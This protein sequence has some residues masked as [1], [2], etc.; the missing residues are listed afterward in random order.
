MWAVGIC[1][2]YVATADLTDDVDDLLRGYHPGDQLL[3]VAEGSTSF[4]RLL[5]AVTTKAVD[6][7]AKKELEAKK[8]ASVKS[9]GD[10]KQLANKAPKM[11]KL[12]PEIVAASGKEDG[13]KKEVNQKAQEERA[14]KEKEQKRIEKLKEQADKAKAK[15]KADKEQSVKLKEQAQKK[16]DEQEKKVI[17]AKEQ[18]K[19]EDE[20]KLAAKMAKLK[21]ERE[22]QIA[23][24][25]KE[26]KDI[27][28]AKAKEVAKKNERP[29][30][31]AGAIKMQQEADAE[32]KNIKTKMSKASKYLALRKKQ[33]QEACLEKYPDNP[34]K[35]KENVS[36]E[37]S[38]S[39]DDESDDESGSEDEDSP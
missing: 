36:K 2:A 26:K 4:A 19:K 13:V 3:E 16:A 1:V 38:E 27:A 12:D 34:E 28:D 33:E 23:K 17:Q 11:H 14:A 37:G 15:E 6:N 32:I 24:E 7:A 18:E 35:C 8:K 20:A 31:K 21:E 9:T 39:S 5:K 29:N 10:M 30:K 22:K 25:K